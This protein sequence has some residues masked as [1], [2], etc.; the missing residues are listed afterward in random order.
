MKSLK[1]ATDQ[2][3]NVPKSVL[4]GSPKDSKDMPV[5]ASGGH[6]FGAPLQKGA[7]GDQQGG[8]VTTYSDS[9]SPKITHFK[10]DI[11][12]I[13]DKGKVT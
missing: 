12:K 13:G 10:P 11:P 4:G 2:N 5:T 8:K 7:V 1:S 6:K 9:D 3:L